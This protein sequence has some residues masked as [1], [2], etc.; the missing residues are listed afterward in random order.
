MNLRRGLMEI[1][2]KEDKPYITRKEK[3]DKDQDKVFRIPYL[4]WTWTLSSKGKMLTYGYAYTQERA[5]D[6]AKNE[7]KNRS[8][9]TCNS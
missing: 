5:I 6:I 8:R 9:F 4:K 2:I 3:R 7:L 1:T